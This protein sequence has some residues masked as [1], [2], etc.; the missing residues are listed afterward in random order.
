MI[1]M[2][3]NRDCEMIKYGNGIYRSVIYNKKTFIPDSLS[4]DVARFIKIWNSASGQYVL[5]INKQQHDFLELE[6][7]IHITSPIRRLVDLLNMIQ[8]QTNLGLIK[9]SE[10]AYQF[11]GDWLEKIDY[12]NTTMRAIRKIQYDC[13]LLEMCVNSPNIM[14]ESYT[15]CLFD[16]IIRNDSLFHYLVY[17]PKIKMLSRITLKENFDNYVEKKFKLYL[18]HDEASLKRKIRLH[19]IR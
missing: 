16:K 12:I 7:Y 1:L 2:N 18:F 17:L 10:K 8:L 11:Y 5:H 19:L 14:T 4:D 6:S 3:Y 13:S 15:G 9:Y